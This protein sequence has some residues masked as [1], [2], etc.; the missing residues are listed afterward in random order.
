M[1]N[2]SFPRSSSSCAE[3]ES[4]LVTAAVLSSESLEAVSVTLFSF[5]S[6]S[7]MSFSIS[8]LRCSRFSSRRSFSALSARRAF[9]LRF[10]A[11]ILPRI[12]S[13]GHS[14]IIA[15]ADFSAALRSCSL[16]PSA[17]SL[18][19]RSSAIRLSVSAT[20]SIM[21]PS[22]FSLEASSAETLPCSAIRSPASVSCFSRSPRLSERLSSSSLQRAAPSAASQLRSSESLPPIF[23]SSSSAEAFRA[24]ASALSAEAAARLLSSSA[25]MASSSASEG[26]KPP[27]FAGAGCSREPHTGQGL[28]SAR[29]AASTPA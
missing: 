21:P 16:L 26:A 28:P 25:F 14:H 11:T 3:T 23:F 20:A 4:A 24:K 19:L 29:P 7:G 5:S 6:V 12:S 9:I 22:C 10:S 2:L 18:A 15:A 13:K 17:V 1:S 8:A 27:L